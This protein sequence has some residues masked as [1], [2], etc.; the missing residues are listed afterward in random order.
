MRAFNKKKKPK[1]TVKSKYIQ[2]G[3]IV[4]GNVVL[5]FD[6]RYFLRPY[7]ATKKLSK[8][9]RYTKCIFDNNLTRDLGYITYKYGKC[10][11]K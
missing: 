9:F 3:D 5:M 4:V 7:K 8:D 1:H 11:S 6:D 10:N 2:F